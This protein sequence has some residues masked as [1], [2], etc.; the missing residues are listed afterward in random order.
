VSRYGNEETVQ[1]YVKAQGIEEEYQQLYV[2]QLE[3]FG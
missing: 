2:Q 1:K 3:L